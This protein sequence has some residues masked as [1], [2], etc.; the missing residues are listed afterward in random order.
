MG[1]PEKTIGKVRYFT[2]YLIFP[3]DK[4]VWIDQS[5]FVHDL[6]FQLKQ[7]RWHND[8]NKCDDL[9]K[10]GETSWKDHNGVLHRVVI[11]DIER[12]KRWGTKKTWN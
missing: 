12:P 4:D 2:Y 10:K 7:T 1:V 3:G 6:Q 11:E 9:L 5:P 8:K